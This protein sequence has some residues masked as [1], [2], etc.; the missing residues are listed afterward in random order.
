[1]I[2]AWPLCKEEVNM[3]HYL[4][5][6]SYN[7]QGIS[8]LV[9]NPQDRSTHVRSVIESLGGRMESFYHAFGD[10]DAVVIAE[11]PDNVSAAAI[12]LAVGAGG[13]M[14]SYKTTVLMTT[15]EAV[16]AMRKASTV[17]YRPP[18]G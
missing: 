12:A 3:A 18:G 7:N 16:E 5:Q 8:D 9:N 1:L 15:D 14:R 10:H 17:G 11:L 4:V 13:A 6:V 2:A